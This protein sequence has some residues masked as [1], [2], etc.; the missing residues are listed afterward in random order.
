MCISRFSFLFFWLA[1]FEVEA[2]ML[3]FMI[4]L[5]ML[6]CFPG[7]RVIDFVSEH[8]H[9]NLGVGKLTAPGTTVSSD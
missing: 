5:V 7:S 4:V 2:V 3:G 9:S 8:L 1:C 6:G